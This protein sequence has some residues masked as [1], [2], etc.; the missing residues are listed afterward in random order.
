MST[1]RPA[2]PP[3]VIAVVVPF[4]DTGCGCAHPLTAEQLTDICTKK[5]DEDDDDPAK[6]VATASRT[7]QLRQFV[8]YMQFCFLPH[9]NAERRAAGGGGGGG[10][11]GGDGEVVFRYLVVEQSRDGRKFNRGKLLNVGFAVGAKFGAPAWWLFHDVDLLPDRRLHALYATSP[12]RA[13]IHIGKLFSR[14]NSDPRFFGGV[15]AMSETHFRATN[16]F[17]NTFFGWG[18]EDE[19]QF[20][21]L[22]M[23]HLYLSAADPVQTYLDAAAASSSSS[24]S[25]SLL[26]DQEDLPTV[27]SKKAS[28]D[29][30]GQRCMNKYELKARDS[31]A[32]LCLVDGLQSLVFVTE[33]WHVPAPWC[34]HYR[35]D[36]S[37]S[38]FL[39][40]GNG[41]DPASAAAAAGS[42]TPE[43]PPPPEA[44][45]TMD[46]F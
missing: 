5:K 28:L 13:P 31:E 25:S 8:R 39:D 27:Q 44:S 10:G 34:V 20:Y 42:T 14:Y 19:S 36:I 7:L 17:P 3:L 11:G 1:R 15:V 43:L 23:C 37:T 18:G 22:T 26:V 4:R 29:A 12:E 16:G 33:A 46:E 41:D 6:P 2:A 40:G 32:N 21:R 30:T 35:V 45:A 38:V 24:S 9:L